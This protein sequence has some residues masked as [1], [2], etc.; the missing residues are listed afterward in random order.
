MS[1]Q[2]I[3]RLTPDFSKHPNLVVMILGMKAI[4]FKGLMTIVSMLLRQV[5]T[6]AAEQQPDGLLYAQNTILFSLRPFHIGLRWYWRDEESLMAWSKSKPH[7][8]WWSSF[9][10]DTRG[11]CFWHETYFMQGGM[12]AM[13]VNLDIRTGLQSFLPMQAMV[14]TFA[15]RLALSRL[16][17]GGD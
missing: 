2:R 6:K 11:T 16:T 1:T 4:S 13:Y 9:S 8:F 14:G 17:V 5:V 7:A 15:E 10:K 3:E 12:E